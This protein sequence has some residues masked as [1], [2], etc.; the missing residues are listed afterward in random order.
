MAAVNKNWRLTKQLNRIDRMKSPTSE[1]MSVR[2]QVLEDSRQGHIELLP[3]VAGA[4]PQAAGFRVGRGDGD[5][6]ETARRNRR[7]RGAR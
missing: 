7:F 1:F 6:A 4:G 3:G 2:D 5:A